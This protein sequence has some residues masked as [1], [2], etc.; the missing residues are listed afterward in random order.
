M[1]FVYIFFSVFSFGSS[2]PI[3]TVEELKITRWTLLNKEFNRSTG[4]KISL[5]DN[6]NAVNKILMDLK[7]EELRQGYLHPDKLVTSNPLSEVLAAI[8]NSSLYHMIRKMPKGGILHAH[9]SALGSTKAFINLTYTEHTWI[10]MIDEDNVLFAFSKKYPTGNCSNKWQLMTALRKSGNFSDE[11]LIGKFSL[12]TKTFTNVKDVWKHFTRA[13]VNTDD[14]MEYKPN[15]AQ[16]VRSY[17]K[18]CFDDGVQYLEI[19]TGIPKVS[20]CISKFND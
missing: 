1:I 6:E 12:Q 9:D 19:R 8:N 13:F 15:F 10:C 3:K 18:E 14:L 2:V 17:L 20:C 5:N 4:H 11:S 16:Y 7:H